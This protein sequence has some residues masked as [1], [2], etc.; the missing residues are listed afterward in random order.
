MKILFVNHLKPSAASFLRQFGLGKE[1]S[2]M[3]HTVSYIGRR[4]SDTVRREGKLSENSRSDFNSEYKKLTYWSE[5]FE[6]SIPLNIVKLIE[7]CR[8]VDL[9]HVNKAYPFTSS[10]LFAA[11]FLAGKGIVLDWED[12]DGIGGYISIANKSLPSRFALGFFEEVVPKSCDSIITV[13]KILAERAK[14]KGIPP[15]KIFQVPNGFDESLF[16]DRVS[17]ERVRQTLGLGSRPTI[18]LVSALHSFE[19]ES[20]TKIFDSLHFVVRKVPNAV[21][22]IAGSGDTLRMRKYADSLGIGKNVEYV[23]YVPHT[24]IPEVIAASD[25]A[26]HI[27][28]DNIYFRSSS[29]MVVPEY[30]AIG[31]PIVASAVGELNTMLKGGAGILV[32]HQ[33]P[34]SFGGAILKL[35]LDI[36]LREKVGRAA[37]SRA[38]E[39]YAY[40]TLAK[41]AE[42][43]YLK[44]LETRS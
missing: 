37:K 23:G 18:L 13:S 5:P 10:L 11:K 31:K 38:K 16:N 4:P 8:D 22:L 14:L 9:I 43:A 3:G 6:Q 44:A 28:S 2:R 26:V 21:L 15:D 36:D 12:W 39:N 40:S 24:V 17:G 25:V 35:L 42:L 41:M 30:M 27:L 7:Q 33:S 19:A 1:L 34:E 20:F 29:P 32:Q